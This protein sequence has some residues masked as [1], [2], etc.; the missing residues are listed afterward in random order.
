MAA[1]VLFISK[2]DSPDIHEAV[3]IITTRLKGSDI[4]YY[5][6]LGWVVN[7]LRG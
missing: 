6:N 7:Y 4:E 3:E 2:G 1:N 5:K